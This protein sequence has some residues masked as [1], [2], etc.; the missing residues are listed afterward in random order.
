MID[1]ALWDSAIELQGF[2]E[3]CRYQF[4]FIGGI[5][6]QRWG[7]PRVTDDMD[8]T[9]I[10]GF[11]NETP[12][13]Q[14]VLKRYQARVSDA[15]GFALQT[16]VLLIQDIAG[17]G[18]DMSLG[19]LPFEERVVTRSSLWGVHGLGHIRTCSA[20]DLVVLKAFASRPQDWIDVEKVIIRQG[21]R[22]NRQLII[23]ELTPLA[24]LK[25][26]PQILEHLQ[27]L[28]LKHR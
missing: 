14:A 4:C 26:D 27:S 22:L 15:A 6:Y 10:T 2:L 20:E 24:E 19:A 16:R 25:E 7:E 13:I 28:L 3:T 17:F 12:V 11:G 5:A 8:V 1:R 21:Q 23:E 18:I 9:V